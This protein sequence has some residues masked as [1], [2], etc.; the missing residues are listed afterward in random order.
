M[1]RTAVLAAFITGIGAVHG[2]AS[3]AASQPDA[4]TR[5]REALGGETALSA[6]RSIR[7]RGTIDR[8]P[9]KDNIE[10]AV[11]L[12]DQFLRTVRTFR[13]SRQPRWTTRDYDMH[14]ISLSR[15][16]AMIV[17]VYGAGE[18]GIE[19]SGFNRMVPLRDPG[20]YGPETPG[21]AE[22]RLES[23]RVRFAEFVLPLLGNTSSA[24]AVDAISEGNTIT[25]RAPNDRSWRLELDPATHLPS[26]MTWTT[27]V[28]PQARAGAVPSRW[29]VDFSEF[30][31]VG[32]VRWP[33]R[34][35]KKLNDAPYEDA[36][37]K[38][39]DLNLNLKIAK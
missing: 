37:I 16:T 19:V 5:L 18:T 24:Y 3:Q 13:T 14:D 38:K 15:T 17:D 28:P 8:S 31:P 7:A 4:L 6:I 12:P 29:Q 33:R 11:V 2:A 35:I 10:I 20:S 32:G 25:F 9:D 34:L 22:R 30:Q 36:R 1:M 23:A 27:P 39:Y 21:S 26:R